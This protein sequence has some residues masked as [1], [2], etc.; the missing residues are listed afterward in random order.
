VRAAAA[1]LTLE[2]LLPS[3]IRH[4]GEKEEDGNAHLEEH[5]LILLVS[6]DLDS[7]VQFDDGLKVSSRLLDLLGGGGGLFG[8]HWVGGRACQL[9][10]YLVR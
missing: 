4:E 10:L 9:V 1:S 6:L 8:R 5:L 2:T 3:S 7:L